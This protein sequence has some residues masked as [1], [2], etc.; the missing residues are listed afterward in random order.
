MDELGHFFGEQTLC[1]ARLGAPLRGVL[2]A[3][4]GSARAVPY[5][6]RVEDLLDARQRE[7]REH[8]EVLPNV[9]VRCAQ[10]ELKMDEARVSA[11]AGLCARTW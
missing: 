5:L 3:G 1:C 8:L 4:R 10:E 7:E 6:M 2:V 9:R 11:W